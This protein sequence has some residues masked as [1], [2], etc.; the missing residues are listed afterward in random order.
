L[1]KKFFR[2]DLLLWKLKIFSSPYESRQYIKN[3]VILVTKNK[4]S[5][6]DVEFLIFEVELSQKSSKHIRFLSGLS[7][8]EISF[9]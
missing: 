5:T 2:L 3:N 1:I 9:Y 6:F 4:I 8:F 7:I